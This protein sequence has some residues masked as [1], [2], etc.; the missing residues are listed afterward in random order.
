MKLNFSD[1]IMQQMEE[2]AERK[3]EMLDILKNECLNKEIVTTMD[4]IGVFD[5]ISYYLEKV[6]DDIIGIYHRNN[7]DK[8][9]IPYDKNSSE[10][11]EE[12]KKRTNIAHKYAIEEMKKLI[13]ENGNFYSV[14]NDNV[15]RAIETNIYLD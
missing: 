12:K 6:Y 11:K 14:I 4:N 5:I 2:Q 15:G 3:K 7:P 13:N 10:Y 9:E 8:S 1:E